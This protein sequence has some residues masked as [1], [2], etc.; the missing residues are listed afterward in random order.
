MTLSRVRGSSKRGGVDYVVRTR[1]YF[2]ELLSEGGGRFSR[3]TLGNPFVFRPTKEVDP[4]SE[5]WGGVPRGFP[6][7][8]GGERVCLLLELRE[9]ASLSFLITFSSSSTNADPPSGGVCV[10]LGGVLP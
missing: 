10:I 2:Y 6:L 5:H 8:F 9:G 3:N 7:Y 1:V 4:P